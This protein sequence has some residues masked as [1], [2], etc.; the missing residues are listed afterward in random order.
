ML[1]PEDL[2]YAVRL[3]VAQEP[4]SF[5]SEMIMRPTQKP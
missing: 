2:A 1:R 3:I 4:N 5:I